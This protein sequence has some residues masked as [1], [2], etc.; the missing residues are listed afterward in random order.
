MSG[1]WGRPDY[2]RWHVGAGTDGDEL[3]RGDVYRL[4]TDPDEAAK[5]SRIHRVAFWIGVWI[6]LNA[7][8]FGLFLAAAIYVKYWSVR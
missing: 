8:A 2:E 1:H 4:T 6:G 3:M 5:E 7:L